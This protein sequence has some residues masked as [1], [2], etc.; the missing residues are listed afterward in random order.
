MKR[1]IGFKNLE[2]PSVMSKE[3]DK[4]QQKPMSKFRATG[5]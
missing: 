1:K 4:E 2:N 5:L 3:W